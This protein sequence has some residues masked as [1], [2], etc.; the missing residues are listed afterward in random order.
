M[1]I[2][3]RRHLLQHNLNHGLHTQIS[4]NQP[5]GPH[6]THT[7][8]NKHQRQHKILA[9]QHLKHQQ[10]NIRTTQI[11]TILQ[12]YQTTHSSQLHRPST[13]IFN[14]AQSHS[15]RTAMSSNNHTTMLSNNHTAMS[16]NNHTAVSSNN[17]TTMS[18]N[19]HTAMSS[20][21]C[22]A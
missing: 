10:N 5:H 2:W 14:R 19:N 9:C 6:T 16:S 4:H 17:H 22:R 1:K 13:T 15:N 21:N 3:T 11:F 7:C 20:N 8:H 12:H 18:S